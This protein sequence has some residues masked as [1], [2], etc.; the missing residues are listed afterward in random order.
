MTCT[1]VL[2]SLTLSQTTNFRLFQTDEFADNN[3]KF[4]ENDRKFS[5]RIEN[6]VRKGQTALYEQF[7][8]FQSVFI[9]LVRQTLEQKTGLV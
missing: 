2:C 5:K 3:F 9:R 4:D 7:V 1:H 6:T 8:L